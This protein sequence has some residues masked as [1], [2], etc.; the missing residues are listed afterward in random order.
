MRSRRESIAAPKPPRSFA[1]TMCF[2]LAAWL[3]AEAPLAQTRPD[4]A[5][6]GTYR[7]EARVERVILDAHVTDNK[8]EALPRLGAADFELRVDGAMVPLESADWIPAGEPEVSVPSA[9]DSSMPSAVSTEA[10]P[11][12]LLIFFF[13]TDYTTSRLIGLVRMGLQARRFLD[14]LLPSDRVAVLSFDSHLKLR[15]DFTDDRARILA[16][17]HASLRTGPPK[18]SE[19]EPGPSLARHFDYAGAQDAVTPEGALALIARA[20]TPLPGG[21][22]M[23]FFGWGLQT[24]GGMSGA[25]PRDRID[26]AEALPAL[27]RARITIFSLDVTDADHH[28]LE[29]TLS[30]IADLTGGTY[31]KTHIFPD[32]A[33]ER[34]RRAIAGRYVLVFKKPDGGRGVHAVAVRLVG[35]KGTVMARGYYED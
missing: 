21:K 27:A 20:A 30:H 24:I 3:A 6:P 14:T 15:Q 23:L 8:G 22:E 29:K 4:P 11:G 5:R 28:S 25:N 9:A 1:T 19:P 16:A 12:R 10:A 26:Y 33:M 31:S 2:C 13:Q 32:A 34:V 17:I 7:D 35:R 18:L